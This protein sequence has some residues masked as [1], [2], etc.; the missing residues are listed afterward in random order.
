M[1]SKGGYFVVEI[2][3][4]YLGYLKYSVNQNGLFSLSG[5]RPHS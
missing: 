1:N 4:M 5:H 2:N 3:F